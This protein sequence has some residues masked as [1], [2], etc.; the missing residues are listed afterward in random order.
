M[1]DQIDIQKI[2][3]I[4]KDA[5]AAIMK[6]YSHLFEVEQKADNSPLTL[7]DRESNRIILGRLAKIL[8]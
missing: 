7:A 3:Q 1:L 5:G 6:I 2:N 4:A 8:S